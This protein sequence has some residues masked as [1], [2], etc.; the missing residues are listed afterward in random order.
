MNKVPFFDLKAAYLELQDEFDAAYRRVMDSGWYIGGEEV[1]AFETEFAAYCGAK[2]CVGVANG[3]DALHLILK[4]YDIGAGDEVIVP[5]NTYIA[6]WLAVSYAGATPVPV[7]PDIETYN[8][9]P[10]LIEAAITEKTKAIMPVHLYGQPAAMDEINAIAKKYKLKVIEDAAQAQGAT[11]RGTRTGSFGR[12]RRIQ[13]LSGQKSGRVRRRGRD[14]DRRRRF[15]RTFANA[16]QLR[17]ETK[18]LQR[19]QRLQ[20]AARPVTGGVSARQVKAS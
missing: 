7:E 4:G 3:L 17:L 11:Y 5:S 14:H 15:S 1:E 16:P 9:A 6:T 8:I 13:L 20:F 18:I 10:K 2:H 12:C 19:S